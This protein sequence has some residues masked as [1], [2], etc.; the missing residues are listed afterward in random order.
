MSKH[1]P[2]ELPDNWSAEQAWSV[3]EFIYQLE[4]LVWDAYE[5]KLLTLVGPTG[6]DPPKSTDSD[7]LLLSDVD[8]EIPF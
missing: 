1:R 6:P 3:L 7:F 4:E 5:E 2:L 8:N